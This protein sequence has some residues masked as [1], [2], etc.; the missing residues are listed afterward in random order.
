MSR[1]CAAVNSGTG[2][3]WHRV[4]RYDDHG[5]GE[6]VADLLTGYYRGVWRP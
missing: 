4:P 3:H 6:D 2:L 5:L 1:R